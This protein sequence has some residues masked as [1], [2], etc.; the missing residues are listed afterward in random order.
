MVTDL[1][2][3]PIVAMLDRNVAQEDM[4]ARCQEASLPNFV[5][6]NKNN[7]KDL[8]NQLIVYIPLM[9]HETTPR[10]IRRFPW[11]LCSKLLPNDDK[12]DTQTY[13]HASGNFVVACCRCHWNMLSE[14]LPINERCDR[15]FRAI[16][17]KL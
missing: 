11:N 6:I 1:S 16:V 10:T 17:Q 12:K 9:H 14:P 7:I 2:L 8:S 13:R 5:V 3:K 15:I 4:C